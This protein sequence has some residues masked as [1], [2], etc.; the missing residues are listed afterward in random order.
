MNDP[1]NKVLNLGI[2]VCLTAKEA[3]EKAISDMMRCKDR[4]LTGAGRIV[5]ELIRKGEE[6]R[7]DIRKAVFDGVDRLASMAGLATK[8]DIEQLERKFNV[9]REGA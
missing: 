1:I 2:G 7:R 8:K 3:C 9:T 5:D 4:S 6:G